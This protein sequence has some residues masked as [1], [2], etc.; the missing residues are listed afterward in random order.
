MPTRQGPKSIRKNQMLREQQI[1]DAHAQGVRWYTEFR[2]DG[3]LPLVRGRR[4]KRNPQPVTITHANGKTVTYPPLGKRGWYIFTE[5]VKSVNGNISIECSGPYTKAGTARGAGS[6]SL[7]INEIG[8][9]ERST[10]RAASDIP[11]SAEL[12]A[13]FGLGTET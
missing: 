11:T 7:T 12:A 4:F 3:K 1:R 10:P 5:A 2:I 13:T 9:V 6:C 8:T